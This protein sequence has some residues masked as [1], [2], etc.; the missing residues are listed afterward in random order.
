MGGMANMWAVR[1]EQPTS[2]IP[3]ILASRAVGTWGLD[4]APH[5]SCLEMYHKFLQISYS[6]A[7]RNVNMLNEAI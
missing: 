3:T 5:R 7:P 2:A 1:D 4:V 6:L